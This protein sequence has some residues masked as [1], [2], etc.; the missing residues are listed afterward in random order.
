[1]TAAPAAVTADRER[2]TGRHHRPRLHRA[3]PAR[4]SAGPLGYPPPTSGPVPGGVAEA[5]GPGAAQRADP[6]ASGELAI[7]PFRGP[8]MLAHPGPPGQEGDTRT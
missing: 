7:R 1:M 8:S 5:T 6:P 3:R 2:R 4:H